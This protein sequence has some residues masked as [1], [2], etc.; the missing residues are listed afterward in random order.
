LMSSAGGLHA[1]TQCCFFCIIFA[2]QQ[3]LRGVKV[4]ASELTSH[5]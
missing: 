2:R 1:G 3:I 5:T 4:N